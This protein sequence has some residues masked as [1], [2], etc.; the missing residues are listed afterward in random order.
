[1]TDLDRLVAA[2]ARGDEA[3]WEEIVDRF[4]SLVWA[5]ARVHRLSRADA[6]DV[7]QTTWL[8]LVENLDRIQQPERLG[9]WLAT[10]ARR[11]SLR[12]LRLGARERPSDEA[13]LFEAPA[14][15]S[16]DR[17]L[18]QRERDGA[19]WEAFSWL[20]ERCKTL[21]RMLVAENEPSYE[22]VSAALGLPIGSIGPTRMRCLDRLQGRL[23]RVELQT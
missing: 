9:A 16:I 6:A 20:S 2:A 18:L 17:L 15:N 21:L 1:V 19:L 5:T 13:D 3:A 10:T 7:A 23:A 8:R 11:E 12:K 4:A 14:D 22:E